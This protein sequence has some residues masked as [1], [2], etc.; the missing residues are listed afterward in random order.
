MA[1]L[2][3]LDSIFFCCLCEFM[4]TLFVLGNPV[5]KNLWKDGTC[6]MPVNIQFGH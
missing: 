2:C 5:V 6:F 3:G 4:I 1:V